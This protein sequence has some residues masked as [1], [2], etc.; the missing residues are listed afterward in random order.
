MSFEID[1]NDVAPAVPWNL[2]I[3]IDGV[4]YSIRPWTLA[5][6]QRVSTL[7]SATTDEMYAFTESLFEGDSKPNVRE[8]DEDRAIR[9]M[10]TVQG[11]KNALAQKK[12]GAVAAMVQRLA[13]K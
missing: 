4:K 8:W 3:T 2:R 6:T 5:D 1:L 9:F 7:G 12:A 10:G 13:T 11:Y